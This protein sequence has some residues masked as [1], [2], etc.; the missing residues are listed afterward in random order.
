M[1]TICYI[2]YIHITHDN[3]Y[4]YIYIYIYLSPHYTYTVVSM[5]Y[6]LV[7]EAGSRMRACSSLCRFSN[8]ILFYYILSYY[9]L[10][11]YAIFYSIILYAD[12]EAGSRMRAAL[13]AAVDPEASLYKGFPFIRDF[14]L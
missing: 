2:T 10:F 13:G 9:I 5:Y 14:P 6:M 11:C 4:I 1:L 3:I 12:R 7:V 8:T